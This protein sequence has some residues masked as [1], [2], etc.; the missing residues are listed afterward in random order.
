M[1]VIDAIRLRRSIREYKSDPIP[2]DLLERMLEAIRLAPSACNNQPWRFVVVRNAA[3]MQALAKASRNQA[4]IAEAPVAIVACGLPDKAYTRMGGYWN[5]A[6]ID[7]AIAIDHL[8]L[9]AAE[10]GLG[11]C[12]IGAFDEREIKQ[13][14]RIPQ[15]AKVVALTPLGFPKKDSLFRPCKP[16]DRKPKDDVFGFEKY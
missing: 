4:F 11:T 15:A 5:S 1:N 7:V 9:A 13:L 8:T 14:L 16:E 6:E 10:A 2:D 3:T 12:W